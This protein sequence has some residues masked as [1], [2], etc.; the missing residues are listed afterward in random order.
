MDPVDATPAVFLSYAGPERAQARQVR[1]A[2][3]Q[4]GIE[5]F[6]DVDFEPGQPVPISIGHAIN[7]GVFL[8]LISTEYLDR[9]FTQLEVSAAVMADRDGMFLPV[10]IENRP[11]PAT[12]KGRNLWT[13]LNGRTYWLADMTDESFD[14]LARQVTEKARRWRQRA[15]PSPDPVNA[16]ELA[17]TLIY[18][19]EDGHLIDGIAR[20]CARAGLTVVDTVAAGMPEAVRQVP[21]EAHIA[22]PWTT[23][24]QGSSEVAEVVIS[25]LATQR[26]LLYLILPG[27]PACP[28]GEDFIRL[29]SPEDTSGRTERAAGGWVRDRLVLRA[30]LGDALRLNDGV[31]F[32]LLGDKFCA[33]RDAATAAAAAYHMAVYQF[34]PLD[35]SRLEAVLAYAAVYRFRGEWRRAAELL[36]YEPV[37]DYVAGTAYSPAALAMDAERLSLD[38]ELGR[39][40]GIQG[41]AKTILSQ[42]LAAGDWPLIIAMHRQ[43]GMLAEVHSVHGVPGPR[44]G[45]RPDRPGNRT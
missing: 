7:S 4:R 22:V 27:S 40:G 9:P 16:S 26:K 24:A 1:E 33:G 28:E 25:A 41:R 29:A 5:V 45:P 13:V 20:Q 32:H 11:A 3:E 8:P 34:P 37:P 15:V 39:I 42:A 2:R 18:D 10:L 19:W 14:K 6:M 38:F 12:E 23:A 17:V 31:P 36:D 43:L 30:R 44:P 21:P 35:E